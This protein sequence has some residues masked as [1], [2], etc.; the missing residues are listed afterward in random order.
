MVGCGNSKLSEEMAN[1]GY[2]HITNIDISS[3][4][5]EKM[6]AI[7]STRFSMQEY[8]VVDATRMA[9]R[10]NSFDLCIDK[11]TFDALACGNDTE[12]PLRLLSEMMRVCRTATVIVTSG[13]PEKRLCY[14]EKVC[15]K[16]EY[17]QIEVSKLAQLINILR[18]ELKDRPLADAMKD[19]HKIFREAMHELA[20]I[21]RIKRL[22]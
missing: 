8:Q 11:G 10:D 2:S 3:N 12:V 7:Y 21:E 17:Q 14:F 13:T 18:T 15:S 6:S 5:I 16:I 19:D 20:A 1:E 22:E 4:V 9:Y